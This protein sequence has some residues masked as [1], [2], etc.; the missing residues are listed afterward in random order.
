M[1]RPTSAIR[2]GVARRLIVPSIELAGA[3]P[4]DEAKV[5]E[6]RWDRNV[7]RLAAS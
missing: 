6:P 3:E 5:V 7:I 1:E 2:T 4:E